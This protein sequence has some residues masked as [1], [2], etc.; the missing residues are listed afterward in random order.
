M[1]DLKESLSNIWEEAKKKPWLI[2]GVVALVI[3]LAVIAYFKNKDGS[4]KVSSGE[5][6]GESTGEDPGSFSLEGLSG[7]FP[8]L[9]NEDLFNLLRGE[10]DYTWDGEQ[11][12]PA[13]YEEYTGY[14]GVDPSPGG[15]WYSDVSGI[16]YSWGESVPP[17]TILNPGST[18]EIPVQM[19]SDP[20]GNVPDDSKKRST[21]SNQQTGLI[22]PVSTSTDSKKT[23]VMDAAA[24]ANALAGVNKKVT[25]TIVPPSPSKK[26]PAINPPSTVRPM[27]G[28]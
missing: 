27:Q 6:N 15:E 11:S 12:T 28:I 16:P 10:L 25:G 8:S 22:G 2:V 26:I 14:T 17:G 19:V 13:A 21:A 18:W 3:I 7:E 5:T 24:V 20:F 9:T 23:G 1:A 4:F